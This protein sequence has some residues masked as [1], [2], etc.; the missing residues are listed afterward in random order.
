MDRNEILGLKVSE[1]REKLSGLGLPTAGRK[2]VLQDRLFEHFGIEV[3]DDDDDDNDFEAASSNRSVAGGVLEVARTP[4]TLRDVQDSMCSFSGSG[5]PT[6][7]KWLESFEENAEVVQWNAL[8]KFIYAKQLLVGAAKIFIR[9]QSG[10]HGW[11]SLKKALKDEFG[12]TLPASEVH[13]LLRN[14]RKRQGEDHKEYLY[15]L[16]ELGKQVNLD[17]VS[18]IGYFI[19]GLP[20]S[21]PNKANLYQARNLRELKEQITVYEKIKSS[22]NPVTTN[23]GHNINPT[24]SQRKDPGKHCFRCGDEKHL[25]RDCPQKAV[26]CFKC[27]K[28]GHIASK[29]NTTKQS[30]NAGP[31]GAGMAGEVGKDAVGSGLIFKDIS[32]GGFKFAA[33]ID[34]GC[35][36]C[37]IRYDVLMVLGEFELSN[38]TRELYGIGTG[39]LTTIGS[40]TCDVELD[41]ETV[42]ITFHVVRER[43]LR[44]GVVLGNNILKAVDLHVSDS[45]V[46]IKGRQR[47]A[48][49]NTANKSEIVEEGSELKKE[50][51]TLCAI[52][53]VR[54]EFSVDLSHL[55]KSMGLEIRALIENYKPVRNAKSPVEM[56]VLLT[57]EIPVFHRPRRLSNVDKRA[58][59][60]QISV[61]LAEGIIQNSTSEYACPIVLVSKRD[62]SKRLCC[63]YR[64]LNA[65]IVRDN[66]PM[67][68]ID[69]VLE[70][71]QGAKV[72]T[73]LD[74]SNGFFHVPM[75]ENSRKYTSF[76]THNGQFEFLFAPFGICNSPAVFCRYIAAVLRELIEV[77]VVVAYMDDLVIPAKD[78]EES[79]LRLKAVLEVAATRGLKVNWSKCQLLKRC[80]DFLGYTIEDGTIK[81]S[82][83]KTMAVEKFPVPSS[84]KGLQRFLGLTSYFRRFI[85]S[86]AVIAKPL[87]DVL[88]KDVKFSMGDVELAAFQQ[89]KAALGSAPVLKLYNPKAVTEVHTDA[90]MHGYGAVLL[91][92]DFDDREFHPVQFMSRKT[93]PFEEKLHSYELEVLAIIE[94]LKKWRIYLIGIKFKIV[95]DCNAFT[96]TLKKRDVPLRVSRWALYLEDFNY[97]IEHRSG[98]RM[99]HV[100]A[101]SR[102]SCL[103]LEDSL[104]HRLKL[105]QM[106]DDWVRAVRAVLENSSYEDFYLKNGILYK[107][108]DTE[109]VVVPEKMEDEIIRT[110]HNQGHFSTKRTQEA[111]EKMFFIPRLSAKVARVVRSCIECIVAQAKEGKKEGLLSPINKEDQPLGTY[112][113]DHV[114]PMELTKKK[115]NHILVVVD[116]FSKFTWLYPSK[117]TAS[118]FVVECLKKQSS[119]F[120]NPKRIISDRG[121]AFT[122]HLFK[123]YCESEGIQHLLIATGVPRGNGQVERIHKIIVPMLT[124]LC[125]EDPNCWYKHVERVQQAI[126]NTPPRS[127][128]FSPFRILTGLE[129]RVPDIPQIKDLLDELSVEEIDVSREEVRKEARLNIEKIQQEN[130]KNFNSKRKEDSQY[131]VD[132]LVAI[133]RTQFGAGLKLKP[134]YLGPYKILKVMRRG[135]YEVEKVGD[136]EGP[137]RTSSV[138]EY[139][140]PWD[141]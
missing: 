118:D 80:I 125:Y 64:L 122:S 75:E 14:R 107:D 66:F 100:D 84:K 79:L 40:F 36:L 32:I 61:W 68:L 42:K 98:S 105:A 46:E 56:K 4:F 133:K 30:A 95:T 76:V 89:L 15:S 29:C 135:R 45:G 44:Y 51:E 110:A 33:L 86:Y 83:L 85:E 114:G 34:T 31:K 120:G 138:A 12:S 6:V 126:N 99:R 24:P 71:L 27:G 18:L 52:S 65:K 26:T 124:K 121:T 139:M 2:L 69:D 123:E 20:D 77:G 88:R 119:V 132:Q 91:Q 62:G 9:S 5:Q 7:E 3:S 137:R 81:P 58:V 130:K 10:I 117:N 92:R 28:L 11:D 141:P 96:M 50:F 73:T 72:F 8:Q 67:P 55:N 60:E 87:S 13:R 59:E 103:I 1:L 136:H 108:P 90:S 23:G 113:L 134:K 57:D 131:R 127:T 38:E 17:E 82:E 129:M 116:A 54:E 112:H 41:S 39:M 140:K 63:D 93:K 47:V 74:L 101:L 111:I 37:L 19:E 35:D 106:D 53:A 22:A 25:L 78:E 102:V 49:D 43:D 21:K 97:S 94:A 16:M 70:R 104:S 48:E 109:L 115:Y 128:K